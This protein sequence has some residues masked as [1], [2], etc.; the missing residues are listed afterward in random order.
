MDLQSTIIVILS[1]YK[2][3]IE[4]KTN[5]SLKMKFLKIWFKKMRFSTQSIQKSGEIRRFLSNFNNLITYS[6]KYGFN[7]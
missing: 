1:L 7:N 5:P 4:A 3:V 6:C 2:I